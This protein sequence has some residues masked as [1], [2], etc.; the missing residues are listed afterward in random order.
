VFIIDVDALTAVDALD[1]ANQV[2]LDRL[3]AADAKNIVGNERA[4]HQR[5]AFLD[6][7][8]GVNA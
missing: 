1:L 5:I 8:S 4:V 2:I 7:I 6:V 3:D